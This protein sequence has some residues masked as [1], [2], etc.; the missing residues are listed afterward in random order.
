MTEQYNDTIPNQY[1]DMPRV[2][3][4]DVRAEIVA[5]FNDVTQDQYLFDCYS[6]L[7]G[8]VRGL[9]DAGALSLKDYYDL[10]QYVGEVWRSKCGKVVIK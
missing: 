9:R 8:Y 2:R 1:P 6:Y 4:E 7:K 3:V 10:R 5:S